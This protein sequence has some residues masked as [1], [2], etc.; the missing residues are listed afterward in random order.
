MALYYFSK[1]GWVGNKEEERLKEISAF[2][3]RRCGE[4]GEGG[5][6]KKKKA[7]IRLYIAIESRSPFAATLATAG[8]TNSG[9]LQSE[10]AAATQHHLSPNKSRHNLV[11]CVTMTNNHTRVFL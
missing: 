3:R 11:R 7:A 5:M 6:S 1:G 4:K 2:A 10:G 8:E 9:V